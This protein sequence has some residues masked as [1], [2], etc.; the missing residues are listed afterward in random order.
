MRKN[1]W[2]KEEIE[3][4]KKYYSIN[5]ITGCIDKLNR[6]K[7]SIQLKRY[8]L[9]IPIKISIKD[10][11]EKDSI[12][13]IVDESK[14]YH[15]CL[16]KLGINN[17]GSSY[18]TL[19]KYIKIYDINTD[20]FDPNHYL[21]KLIEKN[22]IDLKDILVKNSTYSRSRLKERL[23]KEGLK[24]RL[25]EKCGQDEY[26][27]GEK[28]SLI[29]D[30][31]NGINDDHRLEN[32]RI[33]CPNCNATLD[34]HCKGNKRIYEEKQR[35]LD[36]ENKKR[37]EYKKYNNE[38]TDKQIDNNFNKRKVERPPYEQLLKEIDELGYKGI[39]RKYNVSDNSIRKWK[40]HYE[41]IKI[42]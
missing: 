13:K 35:I 18:N 5:G 16:V 12:K 41:K 36:K 30:H 9:N 23:Y 4:L 25:C 21:I 15:E 28:M 39:G 10:R 22:T 32:L 3:I 17:K 38:L 2:S 11:W 34:T 27:N 1:A 19:K 6:T 29:L 33:L 20:H 31:I 40:K 26:W 24:E 42:N 37:L 7:R 8:Q 14:T